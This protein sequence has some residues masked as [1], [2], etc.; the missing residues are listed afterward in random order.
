MGKYIISC[1][2]RRANR[3]G[4]LSYSLYIWQQLFTYQQPW[5]RNLFLN[6][7]ALLVVAVI[8]Y[9]FYEKKFLNYK[10]RFKKV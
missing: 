6:L 7:M 4:V 3:I 5:G 9:H 10:D 1:Y 2:V 8:S